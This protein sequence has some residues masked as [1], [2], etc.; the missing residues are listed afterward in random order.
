VVGDEQADR[1]T[2]MFHVKHAHVR[3]IHGPIVP[4]EFRSL[5]AG[6]DWCQGWRLGPA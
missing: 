5:L 6:R 3:V 2:V 1:L 4:L